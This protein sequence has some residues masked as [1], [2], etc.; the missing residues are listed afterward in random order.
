MIYERQEWDYN[1][2]TAQTDQGD[3]VRV[4]CMMKSNNW[5]QFT[6]HLIFTYS[7]HVGELMK[8]Y[9]H[10]TQ[11]FISQDSDGKVWSSE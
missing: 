7:W 9:F 1:P 11:S 5:Y 6:T 3:D 8:F 10:L 4:V 2:S